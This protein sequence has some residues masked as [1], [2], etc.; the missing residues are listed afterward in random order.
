MS[1]LSKVV[2]SGFV[3]LFFGALGACALGPEK[4]PNL[5]YSVVFPSENAA[6]YV[7]N[8]EVFAF[9]NY[10]CLDLIRDR[11]NGQFAENATLVASVPSKTVCD[12]ALFPQSFQASFGDPATSILVV[13]TR[14]SQGAQDVLIGCA[15]ATVG[16]GAFPLSIYLSSIPR[17]PQSSIPVSTCPSLAAKCAGGC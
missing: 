3:A 6:L 15:T 11:L 7:E 16:D 2:S 5:Q 8:L 9:R 1:R 10:A 4:V 17:P 13:A 12:V 14:P